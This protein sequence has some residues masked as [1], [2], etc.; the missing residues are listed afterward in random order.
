MA[1]IQQFSLI[2]HGLQQLMINMDECFLP[3]NEMPPLVA[4]LNSGVHL[5]FI[6]RVLM[7]DI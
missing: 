6:S 4:D 2:L 7:D 3:K 5:F 1:V